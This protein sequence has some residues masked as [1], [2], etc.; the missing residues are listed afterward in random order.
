MAEEIQETDIKPP[1]NKVAS[2]KNPLV[3]ILV[4]VNTV[5][6]GAVGY[7]QFMTH[8]K[9]AKTPSIRDVVKAE[10]KKIT[11]EEGD[12]QG[13]TGEAVVDDGKLFPL[14]GFTANLAQ[15]DGPR[16]FV[17]LNTVLKFSKDSNEEEFKR[18]KAQ[19]RDSII[20][21]LNG[22]RPDD[23]LSVQGK[24]YLKEEIK[25]AINGFLVDGHVIDVFYVSFQIN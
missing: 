10:M 13:L 11:G 18:R 21:T 9:L 16:R 5:V 14:D 15:G 12:N 23:L 17:R 20:T 1:A 7:F 2:S 6:L 19:I 24:S 25:A 8:Q 4:V 22:K 3:T